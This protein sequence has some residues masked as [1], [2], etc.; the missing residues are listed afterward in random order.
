MCLYFLPVNKVNTKL[1]VRTTKKVYNIAYIF[2]KTPNNIN[3]FYTKRVK[4][5]EKIFA[6]RPVAIL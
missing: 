1:E 3:I 6:A 5:A 4:E 2:L